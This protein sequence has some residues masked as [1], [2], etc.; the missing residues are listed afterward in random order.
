MEEAHANQN[1]P[2][3]DLLKVFKDRYSNYEF[4]ASGGM[5]KVFVAHDNILDKKVAIKILLSTFDDDRSIMRFQR[6]AQTTCKLKH[7]GIVKTLDFGLTELNYPYIIMDFIEGKSLFDILE[8]EGVLEENM[9]CVLAFQVADAMAH[10]HRKGIIHRDL[11]TSNIIVSTYPDDPRVTIIDFGLAIREEDHADESGRLTRAGAI[12]GTPLYMSPEQ[13]S[14][15]SGDERSDVYSLGCILFKMLTGNTPFEGAETL[16]LIQKKISE[17]APKVIEQSSKTKISAELDMVITKALR[18]SPDDRYQTMEELKEALEHSQVAQVHETTDTGISKS[19]KNILEWAPLI[20][21][22]FLLTVLAGG[23]FAITNTTQVKEVK[24]TPITYDPFDLKA[25]NIEHMGRDT[26]KF[27]LVAHEKATDEDL[28]L[29]REEI[30]KSNQKLKEKFE[31]DFPTYIRLRENLQPEKVYGLALNNTKV[32]GH[33]LK[34]L[35]NA[36]IEVL[37]LTDNELEESY[38]KELSKLTNLTRLFLANW[39]F[40]GLELKSLKDASHLYELSVKGCKNL[41]NENLRYLYRLNLRKI[42]F[43]DTVLNDIGVKHLASIG[44]LEELALDKTDITDRAFYLLRKCKNIKEITITRCRKL[45]PKSLE[46]IAEY[47]PGIEHLDISDNK[48]TSRD[49]KPLHKLRKLQA[50]ALLYIP[51]KDVDINWISQNENLRKVGFMQS[52]LTDKGIEKLSGMHLSAVALYQS[53]NISP[54]AV[55]AAKLRWQK[56]LEED[57]KSGKRK[58]SSFTILTDVAMDETI[59]ADMKELYEEAAF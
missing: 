41:K 50:L 44:T 36:E 16:T 25:I 51:V 33:G 30:E 12:I 57:Q 45:T 2:P 10:A 22:V 59:P 18:R 7:Q 11:K 42:N 6:E 17:D 35:E 29:V 48:F 32:K 1:P 52:L 23:F 47:W 21:I 56:T 9:A 28:K 53:K 46:Y 37:D 14:G 39:R 20:S 5:G 54:K 19:G 40:E 3:E 24:P 31:K 8:E 34:Y 49:L 15:K 26:N 58:N 13:A 55:R 27:F 4:I 38:L 43:Q